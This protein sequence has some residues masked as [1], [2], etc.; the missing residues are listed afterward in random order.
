MLFFLKKS[1]KFF[2]YCI[3]NGKTWI[4]LGLR[5]FSKF[6]SQMY[7]Y[8]VL[9]CVWTL[10][11][12]IWKTF[13]HAYQWFFLLSLALTLNKNIYFGWFLTFDIKFREFWRCWEKLVYIF[14]FSRRKAIR[15]MNFSSCD[16][17]K[18][19]KCKLV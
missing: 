4:R 8:K 11:L 15:M 2:W 6:F 5:R 17:K 14:V 1:L 10:N 19:W 16:L 18:F 3:F 7:V 9:N 12:F 13:T